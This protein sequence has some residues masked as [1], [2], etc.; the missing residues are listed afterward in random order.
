MALVS[1]TRCLSTISYLVKKGFLSFAQFSKHL[2]QVE[3]EFY[4]LEDLD[5]V[6]NEISNNG[7]HPVFLAVDE[8][9]KARSL[10]SSEGKILGM[11]SHIGRVLDDQT[12]FHAL[13]T[14]LDPDVVAKVTS[15]SGRPINWIPLSPLS[16]KHS[17]EALATHK[18]RFRVNTGTEEK[19]VFV[20]EQTLRSALCRSARA[21]IADC[22]G[23]P[24]S[25]EYA[26]KLFKSYSVVLLSLSFSGLPS[27][28]TAKRQRNRTLLY[29]A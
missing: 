9:M 5:G 11:L 7:Q 14:S 17:I 1:L 2:R 10:K 18:L 19:P 24:R 22:N 16:Y 20:D 26:L 12:H 15:S 23:H 25:L 6:V 8:L 21:V 29:C 3:A 28:T 27:C 4:F 13:V